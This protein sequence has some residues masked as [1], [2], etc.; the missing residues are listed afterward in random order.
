MANALL[1]FNLKD[2]RF[3]RVRCATIV[4]EILGI[5]Y[6]LDAVAEPGGAS[7]IYHRYIGHFLHF[8]LG[9]TLYSV[10]LMGDLLTADF[11]FMSLARMGKLPP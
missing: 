3:R 7:S 10:V 5:K 4:T 6:G 2:G 8:L 1:E 9:N 11:Q